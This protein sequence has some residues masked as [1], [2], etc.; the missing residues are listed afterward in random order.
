M[1]RTSI[2]LVMG[3]N[4]IFLLMGFSLSR[5]STTAYENY[6][7]YY[8]RS[9]AHNL[10]G[11]AANMAAAQFM[12]NTAWRTGFSNVSFSGGLVNANVVDLDSNR[13]RITATGTFNNEAATT[14]I[15]LG[16]SRFSKFAYYSFIEGAIYWITGD[17]CWGPLHTQQK[18]NV[19]GNP[20]FFGKASAK[21]GL[22][23]SPSS[24][25][26][27]FLGGFQ[28]GVDLQLPTDFNPLRT[29]A[30]GGGKMWSNENVWLDFKSDGKVVVREGSA[31]AT[32]Q[33][34]DIATLAPN[35][36]MFVDG[37][38]LHIKGI[39]NGKVTIAATGS[40]GAA[41]GNVWVDSSIVYSRNPLN[42]W[43]PDM[44]GIVADNDVIVTD[45]S[46]NNDPAKGVT[47][48]ASIL[49]RSGGLKAENYN[50]RPVAGTLTLLGGVQQYQRGPV[51]TFSGS[52]IVSGFQ[53]NYRYDGRLANDFP[54][55]YPA[56]QVYEVL[57]WFE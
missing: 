2:L 17:T 37:G 6:V 25:K 15:T 32:P 43:S 34:V 44:L 20:V 3:F 8:T 5:V 19:S 18:L 45:N 33:I 11:S 50:S 4:M 53:K 7:D 42:G 27:K 47:I 55:F 48:H 22:F 41:K 38:N 36:V 54:P 35:G 56:T 46:N 57:S 31:T 16:P 29:A 9:M 49:S 21:N 12:T 23:K 10:S 26:P 40:S 14:V 30:T 24:S 13:V 52:H 28:T 1:G 51:G 39:L